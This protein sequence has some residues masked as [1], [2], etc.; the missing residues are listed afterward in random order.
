MLQHVRVAW[1]SISIISF[2]ITFS[3]T[4]YHYFHILR[5][6]RG[7]ASGRGGRGGGRGDGGYVKNR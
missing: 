2:L 4:S 7:S 5:R 6:N 1:Q 3:V